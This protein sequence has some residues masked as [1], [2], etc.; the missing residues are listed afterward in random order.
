MSYTVS[1]KN[2]KFKAKIIKI[3]KFLKFKGNNSSLHFKFIFVANMLI[4][5]SLFMNWSYTLNFE[6][7]NNAFSILS[8]YSGY[9]LLFISIVNLFFIISNNRKE[10]IKLNLPIRINESYLILSLAIFEIL[11]ILVVFFFIRGLFTFSENIVY[12]NGIVF[13]FLGAFI[14]LAGS[15]LMIKEYKNKTQDVLF[16]NDTIGNDELKNIIVDKANMK[17]PF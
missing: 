5:F 9:F 7:Q 13:S 16:S 11:L 14:N 3:I 17:L 1:A 15:L 10:I 12:G 2:R 6:L 8:G 4:I